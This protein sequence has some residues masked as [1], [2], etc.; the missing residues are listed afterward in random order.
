MRIGGGSATGDAV[1][2]SRWPSWCAVL[3]EKI[4][5]E[6]NVAWSKVGEGLLAKP[7]TRQVMVHIRFFIYQGYKKWKNCKSSCTIFLVWGVLLTKVKVVHTTLCKTYVE[8]NDQKHPQHHVFWG[9][10]FS[11]SVPMYG[12]LCGITTSV[13]FSKQH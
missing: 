2:H 13:V 7:T 3:F 6:E 4:D 8:K 12:F 5:M 10:C 1:S 11:S 9:E